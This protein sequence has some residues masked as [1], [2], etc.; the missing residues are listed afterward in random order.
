MDN[1]SKTICNGE[2][3]ESLFEALSSPHFSAF[4]IMHMIIALRFCFPTKHSHQNVTKRVLSPMPE[5]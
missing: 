3:K 5:I 2:L 1:G 4:I